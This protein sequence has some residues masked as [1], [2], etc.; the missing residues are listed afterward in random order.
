MDQLTLYS[1]ETVVTA[2]AR[3]KIQSHRQLQMRPQQEKN[4]LSISEEKR[5]SPHK[6]VPISNSRILEADP[7]KLNGVQIEEMYSKA[8]LQNQG[9]VPLH[10]HKRQDVEIKQLLKQHYNMRV[11]LT[12]K[13]PKVPRRDAIAS[14]SGCR[15]FI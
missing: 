9:F 15:W 12:L 2:R 11:T 7:N 5:T 6:T 13:D 10:Q 1:Y 3:Q 4:T 8:P 14:K